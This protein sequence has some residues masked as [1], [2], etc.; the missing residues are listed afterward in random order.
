MR[1]RRTAEPTRGIG[2]LRQLYGRGVSRQLA[3]TRPVAVAKPA[4]HSS[5]ARFREGRFGP[6]YEWATTRQVDYFPVGRRTGPNSC[7]A[8]P[9]AGRSELRDLVYGT[10]T[11]A[12]GAVR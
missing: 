9:S 11:Q 10:N 7:G 3:A 4:C 5:S 6:V 1:S 2:S 8:I 12:C